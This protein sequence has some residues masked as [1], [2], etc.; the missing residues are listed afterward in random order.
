[1]QISRISTMNFYGKSATL[2]KDAAKK[3]EQFINEAL[4]PKDNFV[5]FNQSSY[6]IPSGDF[7]SV[8]KI[9]K[10]HP[11]SP[12]DSVITNEYIHVKGNLSE[13]KEEVIDFVSDG[14]ILK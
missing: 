7:P 2:A 13:P 11:F 8:Q 9:I 1:M 3:T 10:R 12:E 14:A 6:S 5:N 4:K